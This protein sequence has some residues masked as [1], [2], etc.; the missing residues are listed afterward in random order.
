MMAEFHK[1]AR[2]EGPDGEGCGGAGGWGRL[3]LGE[4]MRAVED[5]GWGGE[6]G[7]LLCCLQCKW[8]VSRK[9]LV[10]MVG[11]V[12]GNSCDPNTSVAWEAA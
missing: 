6:G 1:E 3:G 11:V 7:D 2:S 12:E 4:E 8:R 5:G 10:M 9:Y